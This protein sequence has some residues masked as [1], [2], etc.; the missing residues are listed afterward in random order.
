MGA[1]GTCRATAKGNQTIYGYTQVK[2]IA[3]RSAT[4][5]PTTGYPRRPSL[6]LLQLD[7]QCQRVQPPNISTWLSAQF[8]STGTKPVFEIILIAAACG[9]C[10]VPP[11]LA[12]RQFYPACESVKCREVA[13][14]ECE[15]AVH[16][17]VEQGG[18]RVIECLWMPVK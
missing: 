16:E 5:Y 14:L 15:L 12:D 18:D 17:Y 10:Q 9:Y 1:S 8:I 6:R 11:W 13:Q 2:T 3:K 4:T 7:Q